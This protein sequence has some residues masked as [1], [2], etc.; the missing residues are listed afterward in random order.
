MSEAKRSTILNPQRMGLA[1]QKRQDW[2]VDAEEGTNIEDVL[3]PSYWSHMASQMQPY[4]HI[5]VR[6]ETGEWILDLIVTSLGRNWAAVFVANK[7]EMSKALEAAPPAAKYIVK[8]RGPAH[9]FC[10][11]RVLDSETIQEGHMTADDAKA[12]LTQYEKTVSLI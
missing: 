11:V 5:E 2:V 6:L 9:K 8:W 12:A 4:D 1:E 3:Q 7:Y 10:I